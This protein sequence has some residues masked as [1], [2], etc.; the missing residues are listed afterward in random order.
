MPSKGANY[1]VTY[2]GTKS[3]LDY[4]EFLL[5][6][7]DPVELVNLMVSTHFLVNLRIDEHPS[8]TAVLN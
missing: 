2:R 4:N 3:T 5:F 1:Y 7:V 8:A 6:D